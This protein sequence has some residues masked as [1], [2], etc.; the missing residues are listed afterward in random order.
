M[1]FE[2]VVSRWNDERGFGF[3]KAFGNDDAEV[4]VHIS[5]FPKGGRRPA[6][7]ERVLFE[8]VTDEKGKKK[9]KN[10]FC[11][12]RPKTGSDKADKQLH[13]RRRRLKARKP[14]SWL[15]SVFGVVLLVIGAAVAYPYVKKE[16]SERQHRQELSQMSNGTPVAPVQ[17]ISSVYRCDGRTHCSQMTS[18]EEAKFFINNCPGTKMDSDNDGVPCESQWC[19]GGR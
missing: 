17:A 3:L 16:W 4:F 10:L 1:R 13:A 11:P 6:V 15:G 7:G 5:E 18:C 2:G 8:V 19:S 9:A 14:T 12:D